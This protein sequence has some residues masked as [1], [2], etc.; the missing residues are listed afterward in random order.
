MNHIDVLTISLK[1]REESDK[2]KELNFMNLGA[3]LARSW[4]S[5]LAKKHSFPS[6]WS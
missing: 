5:Q 4:S 6:P 2:S 3:S 1:K